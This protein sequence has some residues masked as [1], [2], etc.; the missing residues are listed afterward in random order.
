MALGLPIAFNTSLGLQSQASVG[1]DCHSATSASM[2]SELKLLLQ[3]SKGIEN[4]RF[5][6]AGKIPK[7]V[8]KSVEEVFNLGTIQGAR[9]VGMQDKVGS[10][11]VGKLA[12]L[13]V[14][15]ASSPS[16]VC[17]AQHDAVAAVVLH[18]SPR[19]LEMVIVDGVIRKD[20]GRLRDVD[21]TEGSAIWGGETGTWKWRD[22]S[23]TL[24]AR[25]EELQKKVGAIDMVKAK[26]D[27]IG[28]LF[29]DESK[30]VESV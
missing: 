28:A 6:D 25:R 11:Q 26:K 7:K 15:D 27:V 8:S 18:S 13:C 2:P 1:I 20:Q 30:I 12:D 9:S 21:F 24:V 29:A 3:S 5:I 19:D 4:Q 22:V 16:M 10:L 14:W 23:K 17:A